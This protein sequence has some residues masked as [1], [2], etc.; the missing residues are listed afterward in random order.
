MPLCICCCL[1]MVLHPRWLFWQQ[2][3]PFIER[4]ACVHTK[5][6]S[7]TSFLVKVPAHD[8]I[9][10]QVRDNSDA[11]WSSL[12][13]FWSKIC[14]TIQNQLRKSVD[15]LSPFIHYIHSLNH[16]T[17]TLY[18]ACFGWSAIM[19]SGQQTFPNFLGYE[20]NLKNPFLRTFP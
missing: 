2:Q 9:L 17:L 16:W 14:K 1:W 6:N 19:C 15:S 3:L 18:S 8:Q 13:V 7:A 4:C 20:Y 10:H 12:L 11:M 5:R